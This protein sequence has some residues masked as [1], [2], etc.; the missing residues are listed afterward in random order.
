M[1][2][3]EFLSEIP[4]F[5]SCSDKSI[6]SIAEQTR[7]RKFNAGDEIIAEGSQKTMGFYIIL[8]GEAKV[9]RGEHHLGDYGP[10]DYFGEIA[11]LLDDS[12][13]TATVTA[14]TAMT[15]LALTRWDFKALLKTNPEIGVEVMG[16]LAQRLAATDK[17][18]GD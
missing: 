3:V 5:E 9:T 1:D 7:T 12:P 4:L 6:Q 2:K 14:V 16:V 13:R 15:V 8:D 10:G 18:L 11:L 17:V